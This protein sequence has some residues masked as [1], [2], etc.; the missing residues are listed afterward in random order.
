MPFLTDWS[1]HDSI[2]AC[3]KLP[4]VGTLTGVTVSAPADHV[5]HKMLQSPKGVD[6]SVG[7][8]KLEF[9]ISTKNGS[10]SFSTSEPLGIQ[11]PDEGGIEV[12]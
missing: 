4:I 6:L 7:S 8:P 9:T 11:F 1:S 3:S 2:H 12:K 10:K 5:V